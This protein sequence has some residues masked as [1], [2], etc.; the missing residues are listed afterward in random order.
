MPNRSMIL[1]EMESQA[2]RIILAMSN[3]KLL[4]V[5]GFAGS[6]NNEGNLKTTFPAFA[7][8]R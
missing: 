2:V 1:N 5:P 8:G 4:N 6:Q 7:T 3:N